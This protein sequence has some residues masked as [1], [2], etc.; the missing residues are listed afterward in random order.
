MIRE[1]V[2]E[3]EQDIAVI[4]KNLKLI[5]KQLVT[6]QTEEAEVSCLEAKRFSTESSSDPEMP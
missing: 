4:Q 1:Q 2:K 5:D 3:I 6:L